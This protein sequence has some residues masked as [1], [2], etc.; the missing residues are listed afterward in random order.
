MVFC[1]LCDNKAFVRQTNVQFDDGNV[2]CRIINTDF[3]AICD[4][5]HVCE[6]QGRHVQI[7]GLLRRNPHYSLNENCSQAMVC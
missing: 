1:L 6:D 4:P 5:V 3:I 7:N 2:L